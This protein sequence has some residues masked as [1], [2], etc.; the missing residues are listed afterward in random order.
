MKLDLITLKKKKY[1][2]KKIM[3]TRSSKSDYLFDEELLLDYKNNKLPVRYTFPKLI[4]L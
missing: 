2:L 1:D 3:E 4:L